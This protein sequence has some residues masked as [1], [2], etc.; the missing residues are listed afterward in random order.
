M[1]ERLMWPQYSSPSDLA[2]IESIPLAERN[3]PEST[4][5]IVRR[6]ASRWPASA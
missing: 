4:Y 6:A 1:S 5:A 3:L 2:A